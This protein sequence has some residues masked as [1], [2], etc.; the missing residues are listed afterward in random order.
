MIGRANLS[1]REL[2]ARELEGGFGLPHGRLRD[3]FLRA[4][5]LQI[6][7]GRDAPLEEVLVAGVRE[8]RV[9]EIGLCLLD[10]SFGLLEL[11]VIRA[12]VELRHD[13]AGVNAIAFRHVEFGHAARHEGAHFDVLVGRRGSG[14]GKGKHLRNVRAR[15][16]R[17]RHFRFRGSFGA[18]VVGS[19]FVRAACRA[20]R[21]YQAAQEN[22]R[23][24]IAMIFHRPSIQSSGAPTA[25]SS[26]ENADCT[27]NKL[28]RYWRCT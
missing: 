25:S 20:E 24:S 8:L 13:L 14:A 22:L 21:K 1:A 11:V 3:A 10:G 7:A 26:A 18:R 28:S 4:R 6:L 15:H 12:V 9:V 19:G 17:Q 2:Q 23:V 27:A 16:L 5:I